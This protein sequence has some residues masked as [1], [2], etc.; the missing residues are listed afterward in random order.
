LDYLNEAIFFGSMIRS[1]LL[2]LSFCSLSSIACGQDTL[3]SLQDITFASTSE[4]SAFREALEANR[5]DY[6]TLF[7]LSGTKPSMA[8]KQKFYD[9]LGRMG[10]EKWADKKVDKKVKFVYETI[11]KTFLDKYE[12]KTLFSE[13]WLNGNYNCVSATALY[14]MAF[15]HFQIPYSIKEKPNHVYPVAYPKAQQV[16]VE[17]TNPMVGSFAFNQQFKQ[18]YIE[19]LRKQKSISN[20]EVSSTDVNELFDRYFFKEEVDISFRQLVGIQYMNEGIFNLEAQEWLPSVQQFEK[21]YLFYQNEQVANGLLVSYLKA[22]LMRTKK[23]TIHAQLLGKLSRFAK[24]GITADI[25]KSE[26]GQAANS[27]LFDQGKSAELTAYYHTLD[28]RVRDKELKDEISF[29]YF[30]EHGRYYYNQGRYSESEPYFEKAF[31]LHPNNQEVQGIYLNLVERNLRAT[32]SA[33]EAIDLLNLTATKN[34]TLKSNN[35][36]NSLLATA[37]LNKFG[38]A[39]EKNT[40][41]DADKYRLLF[42]EIYAGNKDLNVNTY[43]IGQAYSSAAVYY[44][45]K[46]QTAKAKMYLNKGLELV[47]DNRELLNRKRALN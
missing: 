15:E 46:N 25:V 30:Y 1:W 3:V 41:A 44:Y 5:F 8:S 7:S 16:I 18:S 47:P 28:K 40:P 33:Q 17:T 12:A 36:F 20:Q 39:F 35:H 9:F 2:S 26:F 29:I 21:A 38:E 42:E 11:H 6:F 32:H 10:Y 31:V 13:I 19:N 45:R 4:A 27:L 24:Y 22:F 34:P 23:D 14:C 37:Y 43:F